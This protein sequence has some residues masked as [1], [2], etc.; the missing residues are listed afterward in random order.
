M[1]NHFLNQFCTRYDKPGVT[2]TGEALDTLIAYPFPGNVRELI[3][4]CER[5]AVM[6]QGNNI[7][8]EDLP[9]GVLSAVRE[10]V[11]EARAWSQGKSLQ[12]ILDSVERQVLEKAMQTHGTQS[13]AAEALGLNQSTVGRKLKRHGLI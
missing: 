11:S 10:Q 12:E 8:R 2:L 6:S 1:I 3:N 7:L 9:A 5:L 13:R 4:I